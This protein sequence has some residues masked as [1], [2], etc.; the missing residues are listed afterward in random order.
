MPIDPNVFD[1]IK[2]FTD[3]QKAD[4]D[5]QMR[6]A[7]A[8]QQLQTGDTANQLQQFQLRQAKT[9]GA[10]NLLSSVNDE[11]SYQA[12]LP[13]AAQ[14]FGPDTVA[15]APAHYDPKWVQNTQ[16]QLLD[17]KDKLG[18]NLKIAETN[19]A[20]PPI[21]AGQKPLSLPDIMSGGASAS[22]PP[23]P[24]VTPSAAPP[25]GNASVN[26]PGNLRPVGASTGFQ[27]F[28]TPEDGMNALVNDITAKASGKSAVMGTLPPT[29]RNI[30]TKY[31]PVADNNNPDAY[32]A[33]VAKQAGIDPDRPVNVADIATKIAPA[34]AKFEGY[35]PPASQQASTPQAYT[36][37]RGHE[38]YDTPLP[39]EAMAQLNQYAPQVKSLALAYINGQQPLPPDSALVRNSPQAKIEA[40]AMQAAR[41]ADPA[42]TANRFTVLKSFEGSAP[43]ALKMANFGTVAGHLEILRQLAGALDNGDVQAVNSLRN[44]FEKAFGQSPPNTFDAFKSLVSDEITK[45]VIG[46]SG[47]LADREGTA[48]TI[49]GYNSP[50]Q[51]TDLLDKAIVPA[52]KSQFE[53]LQNQ[54]EVGTGRT[55]FLNRL[56]PPAKALFTGQN[57]AQP[58]TAASFAASGKADFDASKIA[59]P[60]EIAAYK[61]QRGIK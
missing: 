23:A 35:K 9:N 61:K 3:Y 28:A 4:Q 39:P 57:A 26:N 60:A 20:N 42:L 29:L 16:M 54:Y 56:T 10:L 18:A 14:Q 6:K 27:Q 46:G 55:D 22:Q 30:I 36:P 51:I 50:T 45:G 17:A 24:E 49:A 47:A 1:K 12:A 43:N 33:F 2:T 25:A 59:T 34:M 52:I 13:K 37:A 48:K 32:T 21:M 38:T 58:N 44:S 31:A 15:S 5:F 11:A 53:S 8:A 40:A 19:A 7:L 41:T